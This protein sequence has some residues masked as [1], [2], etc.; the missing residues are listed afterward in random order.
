MFSCKETTFFRS[1]LTLI[2]PAA[3]CGKDP[4]CLRILLV[5]ADDYLRLKMKI[6]L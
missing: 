4:A 1:S 6:S 3:V 2:V 5:R